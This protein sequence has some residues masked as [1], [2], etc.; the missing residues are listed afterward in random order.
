MKRRVLTGKDKHLQVVTSTAVQWLPQ[1][2]DIPRKFALS[3]EK[4]VSKPGILRPLH[5]QGRAPKA[6]GRWQ[7]L[8]RAGSP[9]A[10]LFTCHQVGSHYGP[11]MS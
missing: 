2:D 10:I 4:P 1:D 11:L 8:G 6:T 3:R 9:E 7:H 5:D